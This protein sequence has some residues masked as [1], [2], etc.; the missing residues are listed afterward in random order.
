MQLSEY[1]L[2]TWVN[3]DLTTEKLAHL[4]T[5]AGLEVEAVDHVAP[6]FSGVMVGQVLEVDKHPNADRLSVC[7]V[8]VGTGKPLNI[9]CGATN[10]RKGLKVACATI[11]ARL[12]GESGKTFDI[13][14]VQ[15]RGVDSQGMLCAARELGIH[16]ES[17]G[18]LEL[19]D[20]AP[21]GQDFRA[22]RQLDDR[23]LTL[24]LTPNRADCLSIR[25]VAREVAALTAVNLNTLKV[26]TVADKIDDRFPVRISAPHA[27]G[28]F[29][30]RV[31]RGVNAKAV[32]PQ[33][34]KERL[35]RCG[36]RSISALVDVTNYVM[37][38]LGQ[39]LHVY[40]L[41]KLQGGIDVR[42]ARQGEQLKLLNEQT[43][44][45]DEDLLVI[46]D[47]GGVIGLAGI[48]GGDS[49]KA[50]LDTQDIFLEAAFFHPDAIA[51]RARRFGFAS[52]ASHRFER[53]VD[54]AGNLEAI[55]RA[56][57]LII[58][59]CG[60][61]AGVVVDEVAQL[62]ARRP[63]QL[64][65]ARASKIIGVSFSDAAMLDIFKRLGFAATQGAGV[66]EV[67]P[68]S[69]RFDIE[70]E[71]DLIEEVARIYGFDNIPATA[72]LAPALLLAQ[73]E[74]RRSPHDLRARLA[75]CDYQEVVNFSFVDAQWEKDFAGNSN[76]LKLLNPIAS[77]MS[78]MRSSLIGSLVANARYNL[79]HKASRVRIFEIGRVFLR[80]P[81]VQDGELEV[82]GIDQPL[83]I[84]GLAFGS[85]APEQ[86]G[87]ATRAVDFF[88]LKGD[89]EALLAPLQARFVK[90]THPS[91][92]PGRSARVELDGRLIGWVG[93]LH[94]RWQQQYEIPGSAVV[95]ELDLKPLLELP[96]PRYREVAKFPAVVR[97]IA[98]VVDEAV[99][100]QAML[101]S[102]RGHRTGFVQEVL[103]F[104][105][106]R[107]QG[108]AKGRKS[109]AFRVV[110]Q[111][112]ARTLTDAEVAA[113]VA[114][115][116]TELLSRF[117]GEQRS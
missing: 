4:L 25:G 31:I 112:T 44:D 84:A 94:P 77:Q 54:F 56:T 55:E 14:P 71:E 20:D 24:K 8:D 11:G 26:A 21:V 109:V 96:V 2:R 17:S 29:G 65:G 91:L 104:D 69:Y 41:A 19:A 38:E 107:G 95:F 74:D 66:L 27:C 43:I 42:L 79:S 113:A 67:V 92:H 58:D 87:Q 68:P 33:W 9:V 117:G 97:D 28:R 3:P 90:G 30:G 73:P 81:H 110:M 47:N 57:Q 13:K 105:L 51:G 75:D 48:M 63:V 108:V 22:Y 39:P 15:M 49:S 89:V 61:E 82:G 6:P 106:Y 83:R 111:D 101:D 46:A 7:Q 100:A 102:L 35:L 85:A 72:P 23:V 18:L 114:E 115:L 10:V 93:E 60:G 64:R 88:D 5:M 50:D 52:D 86:W 116:S 62:P 103:L 80:A 53:G 36:Q 34:M 12:P 32:T 40:D 16:D 1:W 78:V 45:L 70:I 98:I 76:P 37:L 99:S 59:I